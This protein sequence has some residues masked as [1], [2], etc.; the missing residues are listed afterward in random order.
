M[1]H[2]WT[3][4]RDK[5]TKLENFNLPPLTDRMEKEKNALRKQMIEI[6]II[7]VTPTRMTILKQMGNI[8]LKINKESKESRESLN[9]QISIEKV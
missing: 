5:H 8:H 9:S 4:L 7:T 2:S 3:E 6:K 1:K